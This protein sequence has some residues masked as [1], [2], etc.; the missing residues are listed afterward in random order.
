MSTEEKEVEFNEDIF[1]SMID[2]TFEVEEDDDTEEVGT[3]ED[4]TTEE[5]ELE[6]DELEDEYED[7]EDE[8]EDEEGTELDSGEDDAELE[9]ELDDDSEDEAADE[10]EN[11][12]N[13][14]EAEDENEE[15]ESGEESEE[16][17]NIEE[18][19][20]EE[21]SENS[22]ESGDE[23]TE[24]STQAEASDGD[25]I[26]YKS[27]YDSVVN[28][29][30][31]VNG[32][33]VKGF[34]DPKKIIQSM[35]MA[36]GFSEKMAGFKKYRPFLTPLKE[37]D[38]L[39][40]PRKFDLAMNI[41]DG[42]KE[43]IKQHLKTLDIDP[44][45][46]DMDDIKYVPTPATASTATITIEDALDRAKTGGYE[47]KLRGVL[48]NDWDEDSFNQF[49]ENPNVRNDLLDHIESGAYD[50]V[51]D[52]MTEI[53]RLDINGSFANMTAVDKYRYAVQ[54]IQA[55]EPQHTKAPENTSNPEEG[56]AIQSNSTAPAESKKVTVSDEKEKIISARKAKKYKKDLKAKEATISKQRKR[57]ASVS[58]KKPKAK[59][60]KKFDPMKAEGQDLDDL[61][62]LLISG[63]R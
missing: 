9:E 14:D 62:D 60:S 61:M 48:A 59:S 44:L 4:T 24:E 42:D 43:A 15:D 20:E 54:R 21:T 51:K 46:L 35:Q 50:K 8:E 3:E 18:D 58:K 45:E 26:D 10:D 6:D 55:E 31:T 37:R 13:E 28:T 47:E 11:E 40:D 32:K 5:E 22:E 49:V 36:G 1:E 56:K 23:D 57:A 39:K 25:T 41:I 16:T 53:S 19:S 29:E 63:G 2:G 7:E 38:M 27:F 17:G 12:E 52:K 30:F 33:K 34:A